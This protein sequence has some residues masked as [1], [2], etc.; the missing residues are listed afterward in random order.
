MKNMS[1]SDVDRIVDRIIHEDRVIHTKK[2]FEDIL[3]RE[4]TASQR[5]RIWVRY[6]Y[7]AFRNVDSDQGNEHQ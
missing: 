6:R 5:E 4:Y 3:D 7:L 1:K 2:E